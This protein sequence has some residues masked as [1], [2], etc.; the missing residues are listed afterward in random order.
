MFRK[1]SWRTTVAGIVMGI[2]IVL[3]QFGGLIDM[4]PNTAFDTKEVVGGLAMVAGALGLG[5]FAK[6]TK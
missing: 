5:Y 2:G 1:E 6:A 4:D 3:V